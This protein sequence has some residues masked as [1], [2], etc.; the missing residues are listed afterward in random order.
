MDQAHA[1]LR[2]Y[3]GYDSFRPLQEKVVDSLLRGRDVCVVMP[4]GGGKSLCYQLPAVM[5]Q[6]TAV[7]V[8]PLI[9]LMQDQ[10]AQLRAQG[11]PAAVL[12]S[13]IR[14]HE[15][16]QV[17]REAIAGRY[18]L[19]YLSPERLVRTDTFEFLQ[20]VPLSFFVIDEAHCISEWGHEFRPEYRQLRAL[21]ERFPQTPIAAFTASA[22]RRVRHDILQQLRLQQPDRFIRSFQRPNLRY[23][24]LAC[25]ALKQ[26]QALT[27]ALR[28]HE[29]E[30]IIVYAP[31]IE[32]VES[33]AKQLRRQGIAALPYHG[34]M[35]ADLRRRHQDQ[36]MEDEARVLVGTIAFGMGINKP[37]VRAVIHLS[38]PKSLEQYYQEAGRAG[39][40]GD[41]ADCLLLWQL[42]DAGLLAFFIEKI[43]DPQEKR[44]SWE[45]YHDMR[46]FAEKREC[47]QIQICRHFG[48]T[49]K[50][51]KCGAC[52]VCAGLPEYL[53]DR[54]RKPAPPTATKPALPKAAAAA[55]G[56]S[57]PSAPAAGASIWQQASD[58]LVV[59]AMRKWRRETAAAEGIPA[60]VILHDT[61]LL[62]LCKK[63]PRTIGELLEVHGIG[64]AKAAKYGEEIL[65][66]LRRAE[67]KGS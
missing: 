50:W 34:K 23:A 1:A 17:M 27:A 52:D 48:E 65:K 15:Q 21:R 54:K 28:H 37:S 3:W 13:T 60:F 22:T 58:A 64:T 31:T 4:T 20:N 63:R 36:W 26:E 12:N 40:D 25:D 24:V 47:R 11:I 6:G 5:R 45:R 49:P 14:P 32:R 44:R 10:V 56:G 42:K 7:V 35:E 61:S 51:E 38:L 43:E 16:Q 30:S 67:S 46:G 33:T 18:R 29:G 2:Q 41:P 59:D 66:A 57:K 62:D 19:L 9:A 53:E 39:R 55:S 8:S